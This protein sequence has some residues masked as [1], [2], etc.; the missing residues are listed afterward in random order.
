LYIVHGLQESQALDRS[1]AELELFTENKS[2][3]VWRFVRNLHHRPYETTLETFSKLTD[4]LCKYL[5][6]Y[7]PKLQELNIMLLEEHIGLGPRGALWI[8]NDFTTGEALGEGDCFF[9]N[10]LAQVMNQLFNY[11]GPVNH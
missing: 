3:A 1:F 11:C 9:F 2:D 7:C 8:P 5:R 10:T 4:Y 6:F